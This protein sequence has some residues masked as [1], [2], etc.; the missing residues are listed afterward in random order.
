MHFHGAVVEVGND[1]QISPGSHERLH[2]AEF[3]VR[4]VATFQLGHPRQRDAHESRDSA[5]RA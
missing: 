3:N 5:W 2:G 1:A 4:Q